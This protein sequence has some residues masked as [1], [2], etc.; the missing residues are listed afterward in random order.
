MVMDNNRLRVPV[1]RPDMVELQRAVV[2]YNDNVYEL[3]ETG[4]YRAEIEDLGPEMA[5]LLVHSAG[6][7][8]AIGRRYG[9]AMERKWLGEQ[10]KLVRDLLI[11]D[12]T[13]L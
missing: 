3:D 4:E 9:A 7:A 5:I 8:F 2:E 11:E 6:D 1:S 10:P 12:Y 13:T